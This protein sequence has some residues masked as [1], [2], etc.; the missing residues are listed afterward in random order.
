DQMWQDLLEY[1]AE[2]ISNL[3]TEGL[4]HG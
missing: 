4:I 2:V 1:E 3:G